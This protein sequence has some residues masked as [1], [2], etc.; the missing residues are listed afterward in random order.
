MIRTDACTPASSASFCSQA[1]QLA[2]CPRA[3][4]SPGV[5]KTCAHCRPLSNK[6]LPIVDRR[7]VQAYD[8]SLL[9][10]L[11]SRCAAA[12]PA[13]LRTFCTANPTSDQCS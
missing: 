6:L 8:S 4:S 10:A 3:D 12:D 2:H 5:I 7:M 9:M 13:A 1:G 11:L